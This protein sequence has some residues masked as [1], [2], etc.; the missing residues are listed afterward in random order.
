VLRGGEIPLSD[1][2]VE[3]LQRPNEAA[4]EEWLKGRPGLV[5]DGT[6]LR[7]G[8]PGAAVSLSTQASRVELRHAQIITYGAELHISAL[9]IASDGGSIK[10]F[11]SAVA[12]APEARNGVPGQAGFS[13]GRVVLRGALSRDSHLD[14]QLDGQDGAQG[15]QGRTAQ[16][17]APGTSGD[18]AADHT[19]D[20][21]H[22]GGPG[23]R[24]EKAQRG[25]AGA[26]GGNGGD[27]GTLMVVRGGAA[28]DA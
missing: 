26:P 4:Y 5:L 3:V 18:H 20:C 14:I 19:F 24:G 10:A 17:G 6:T 8:R 11:D 1:F 12:L 2:P 22:G 25:E 15:G 9:Q 16:P 23:G 27:G 21:A 28:A 7:L 13:R